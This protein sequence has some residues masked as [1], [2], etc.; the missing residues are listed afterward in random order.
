MRLLSA[1]CRH[2]AELAR[3]FGL[4][5]VGK[6]SIFDALIQSGAAKN[7]YRAVELVAGKFPPSRAG[8]KTSWSELALWTWDYDQA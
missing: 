7:F 8:L 3:E 2:C 5:L 6:M 1:R 4:E